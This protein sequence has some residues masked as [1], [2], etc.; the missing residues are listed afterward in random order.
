MPESKTSSSC[1]RPPG[2]PTHQ[3][4]SILGAALVGLGKT[5]EAGPFLRSGYE[6]LAKHRAAIPSFFRPR[7]AEALDRLIDCSEAAGNADEVKA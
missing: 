7:V 2:W 4:R 1:S 3:T 6:G 5:A